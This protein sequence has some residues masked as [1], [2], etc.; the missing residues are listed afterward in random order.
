MAH[1]ASI[2]P[3]IEAQLAVEK[4]KLKR[5]KQLHPSQFQD[6]PGR[7]ALGG[8]ITEFKKAHGQAAS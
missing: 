7:K 8:W 2:S 3:I 1:S 5:A 6:A 4:A